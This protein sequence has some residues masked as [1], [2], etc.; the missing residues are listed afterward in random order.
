M[1]RWR[2]CHSCLQKATA[3]RRHRRPL[4]ECL[5]GT[6][7]QRAPRRQNRATVWGRAHYQRSSNAPAA[8]SATSNRCVPSSNWSMTGR[9]CP[10][11]FPSHAP[12][13]HCTVA[14]WRLIPAR[15]EVGPIP[16]SE[17]EQNTVAADPNTTIFFF[18]FAARSDFSAAVVYSASAR[19]LM[20]AAAGSWKRAREQGR[21]QTGQV[22]LRGDVGFCVSFVGSCRYEK[23]NCR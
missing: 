19:Q 13:P 2:P 6:C 14:G 11:P 3:A 15:H 20:H 23:L 16:E 18:R 7:L 17:A 8:P 5:Q 22:G 4:L 21:Q 12:S 10:M 1:T 9:I